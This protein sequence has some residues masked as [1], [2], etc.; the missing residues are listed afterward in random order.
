MPRERSADLGAAALMAR[1]PRLAEAIWSALSD[2]DP[3]GRTAEKMG[4]YS[5]PLADS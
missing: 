1:P 4:P 2:W 5:S 3:L